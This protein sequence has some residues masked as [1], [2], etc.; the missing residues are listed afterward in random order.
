MTAP[1]DR[2]DALGLTLARLAATTQEGLAGGLRTGLDDLLTLVIRRWV[3]EF[4]DVDA[5]PDDPAEFLAWFALALDG[6]LGLPIEDAALDGA[7]TMAY[8]AGLDHAALTA[9]WTPT[10]SVASAPRSGVVLG[11]IAREQAVQA[12]SGLADRVAEDGLLAVQG[13]LGTARQAATRID[14]TAAVEV[15]AAAARAVRDVADEQG[16]TVMW[17]A[18]RDGCLTCLAYAG[19]TAATGEEFPVDLT[20]GRRPMSAPGPIV[21]PARHPHCRCSL[22]ILN[23]DDT[24]IPAALKR[25]ARRSVV[26]GDSVDGLAARLDAAD[27]LLARGAG[28]P[29][30]VEHRAAVAVARG[31]FG[32]DRGTA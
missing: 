7:V 28:L 3:A 18:E 1:Q 10:T 11:A 20:F 5:K 13:A 21:G 8:A 15:T 12:L 2:A 9:W 32:K 25:E 30:T 16:A 31:Q 23:P 22:E 14:A 4:G 6:V 26:R 17:V 24:A 27:R 19:A 29:K